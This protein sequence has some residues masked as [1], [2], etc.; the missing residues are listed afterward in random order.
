MKAWRDL[1]AIAETLPGSQRRRLA[2]GAALAAVTVLMGMGLVGFAL[3]PV[4]LM[5]C[6]S[7]LVVGAGGVLVMASSNTALQSRVP[8]ELRGRIMSIF[9]MAFT[10]TMPLGNLVVGA[11][12]NISG[13]RPVLVG[14]GLICFLVALGFHRQLPR[15][16]A[17]QAQ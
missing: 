14:A 12:A 6:F 15:L 1:R 13:P 5:A 7:L 11:V 3:S 16:R 8:E 10:G 2:L 17:T 4:F 9:T